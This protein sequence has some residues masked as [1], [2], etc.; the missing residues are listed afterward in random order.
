MTDFD[1]IGLGALNVD[2]IYTVPRLV[3]DG[4]E[5]VE[6]SAVEAGGCSANTVY[7]LARLG[8]R[9][10]FVGAVG[11]DPEA[12]VVLRSF[13]A[14]GVDTGGVVRLAGAPTGSVIALTD[15]EGNRALYLQPGANALLAVDAIDA[16]YLARARLVHLSSF[17]GDDSPDLQATLARSLAGK[18]LVALSLDGLYARR[19]LAALAPLLE[20]CA[21]IF[22]N[23]QELADLTRLD[24]P[25]AAQALLRLGCATVVVTFGGGLAA[26]EWRGRLPPPARAGDGPL[27]CYIASRAG[28][29]TVPALA[30]HQG[31]LVDAT[32]AGDAFAAGFLWGL[33]AG[34]PLWECGSLGHTL[35]GF[36]ITALGC[37]RG[38]PSAG[39]LLARHTI[40]FG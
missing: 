37:R 27:A 17:A 26:E 6:T 32:G 33:L 16:A 38:L 24:L 2:R 10:G 13:A 8:L 35:A 23:R 5:K 39:D 20:Q 12:E 9:C 36:C 19:G 18:A 3:A 1:V 30:T 14:A 21:V 28:V 22:A 11:D 29:W 31:P 40:H 7:A 34:R 25:Q 15:H 4:A